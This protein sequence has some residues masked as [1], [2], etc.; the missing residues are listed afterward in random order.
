MGKT[1]S[2]EPT[3]E[4]MCQTGNREP[5]VREAKWRRL[6]VTAI[7]PPVWIWCLFGQMVQWVE[8]Q[9]FISL[10]SRVSNYEKNTRVSVRIVPEKT[11]LLLPPCIVCNLSRQALSSLPQPSP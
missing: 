11:Q 7:Q 6:F 10:H 2:R 4:A 1:L 8:A 5:E 9:E 3:S